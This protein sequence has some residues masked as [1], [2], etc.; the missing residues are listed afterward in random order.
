MGV[1]AGCWGRYQLFRSF[2]TITHQQMYV[3]VACC[4]GFYRCVLLWIFRYFD[5]VRVQR[6][7][8]LLHSVHTV[9]IRMRLVLVRLRGP[10]VSSS[11][12]FA[13]SPPINS[14]LLPLMRW[15]S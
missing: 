12:T 14:P 1:L 3:F 15:S 10:S 9:D 11:L 5:L 13:P 2:V 8:F 6:G 4:V 7:S